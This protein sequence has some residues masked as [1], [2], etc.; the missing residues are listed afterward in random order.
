MTARTKETE[1]DLTQAG[2]FAWQLALGL[3][4]TWAWL[5]FCRLIPRVRIRVGFTFLIAAIWVVFSCLI[6][7][8]GLTVPGGLACIF[9][10]VVL[11]WRWKR[12]LRNRSLEVSTIMNYQNHDIF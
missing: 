4:P 11:F 8:N 6:S 12:A 9:A 1:M 5:I 3:L 2:I 7:R 10:E